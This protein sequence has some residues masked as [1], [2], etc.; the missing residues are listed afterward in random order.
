MVWVK[1]GLL[2][3]CFLVLMNPTQ[4]D[5]T[6]CGAKCA[7]R[8]TRGFGYTWCGIWSNSEH[9]EWDYC[10]RYGTT[11]TGEACV[12]RCG[13]G[14]ER[15]LYFWCKTRDSW[16]YCSPSTASGHESGCTGGYGFIVL[17]VG[18]GLVVIIVCCIVL[19]PVFKSCCGSTQESQQFTTFTER[20]SNLAICW[21]E[22]EDLFVKLMLC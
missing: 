21:L 18:C 15:T 19:M 6:V 17:G 13:T 4:A 9:S 5:V 22:N 3:L 14:E 16:N 11:I 8:C 7:T 12:S 1:I 2:L 20:F 10:S